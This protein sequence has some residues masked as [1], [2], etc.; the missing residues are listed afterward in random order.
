MPRDRNAPNDW[1]AE[2][3]NLIVMVSSGNPSSPYFFATRL[4]SIVPTVRFT[5]LIGRSSVTFSPFS[6]AGLHSSISL[7]SSTSA[8]PWSCFCTQ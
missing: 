6:N 2:P 3:E 5:F 7:L 4:E 8:R 1:P